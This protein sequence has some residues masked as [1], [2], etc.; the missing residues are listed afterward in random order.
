MNFR[1]SKQSLAKQSVENT[2]ICSSFGSKISVQV[3]DKNRG[4]QG[5]PIIENMYYDDFWNA[6]IKS[7]R[8][9]RVITA[10]IQTSDIKP[11]FWE[12]ATY[13]CPK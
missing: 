9:D 3:E 10:F 11:V 7:R 6:D 12:S 5:S 2:R 1:N 13:K 8:R 4:R